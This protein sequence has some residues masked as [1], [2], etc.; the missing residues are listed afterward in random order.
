[1]KILLQSKF[2]QFRLL[3]SKE[4]LDHLKKR[5]I[6]RQISD[7]EF[8]DK[9]NMIK[10]VLRLHGAL[11]ES[12]F[13]RCPKTLSMLSLQDYLTQNLVEFP[14]DNDYKIWKEWVD[15]WGDPLCMY[16]HP[17]QIVGFEHVTNGVKLHLGVQ[18]FLDITDPVNYV[19]IVKKN[20][21]KD[22][23]GWQKSMKDHWLPRMGFLMLL[24]ESYSPDVTQEYFG[25]TN[26]NTSFEKW[27][28]WKSN[29][30]STKSVIQNS[31]FT[32]EDIFALYNLLARINHDDPLGNWFPLQSII[33][34]SRKRQLIGEA[35]VS[36]D[37]YDFATMVRHFIK[38]E[39]NEDVL[40]PDDL[41]DDKWH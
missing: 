12:V 1:M 18:K 24:E 32:K 38:D 35:L 25:G 19:T 23:K 16:Y 6:K 9:M 11:Q 5:G 31:S 21:L 28:E 7:L 8:Y 2:P 41:G 14:S 30:F 26:L 36:Q 39:F 3:D 33:K 27:Q 13:K 17:V 10:P 15:K 37:Y 20:Y 29:E 22:L 34:K 40:P 4:F